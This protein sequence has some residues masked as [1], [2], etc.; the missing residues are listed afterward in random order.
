MDFQKLLERLNDP[1]NRQADRV[2]PPNFWQDAST[3][4]KAFYSEH[5]LRF[6][7]ILAQVIFASMPVLCFLAFAL[8]VFFAFAAGFLFMSFFWVGLA[9]CILV[10]VLV[11]TFGMALVTW[12]FAVAGF[13]L[14]RLAYTAWTS[15]STGS[16]RE[17]GERRTNYDDDYPTLSS[18]GGPPGAQRPFPKQGEKPGDNRT[19]RTTYDSAAGLDQ[20]DQSHSPFSQLLIR[21]TVHASGDN[22]PSP[23]PPPASDPRIAAILKDL[24]SRRAAASRGSAASFASKAT[25]VVDAPASE[26]GPAATAGSGPGPQPTLSTVPEE[27]TA[28]AGSSS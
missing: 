8:S 13:R 16:G 22:Q 21:P 1:Q 19:A 2:A 9:F 12:G 11:V 20:G 6:S 24:S 27:S 10:P 18:P 5:P 7:F 26:S 14:G 15:N 28:P 23:A 17:L 3:T 25:T 4:M